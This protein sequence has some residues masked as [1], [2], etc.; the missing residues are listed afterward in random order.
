[1]A[2]KTWPNSLE[3]GPSLYLWR[4]VAVAQTAVWFFVLPVVCKPHWEWF[5]GLPL[6]SHPLAKQVLLNEMGFLYFIIACVLIVPIYAGNYPFFEQFRI[7]DQSNYG[8]PCKDFDF[9][10][11]KKEVR[12]KFWSLTKQ[13]L[14]LY[15]FNYG[16][17][18]PVLTVGKFLV[19][20]D[21][22]SFSTSDWPSNRTLFLHNIAMTLIHEFAFYWSHRLA[23]IPSLYRYHKVH[24]AYK[25]NTIMASM[26]EHPI[27]YIVTIAGPALL[28]VILV[29]PHSFTLF[30][31][32]AW[33][34]VA[35]IDDHCGYEFPF[36]PVRWFYLAG[37]TDMH[38]YHHSHSSNFN[39]FA[40]KLALYDVLFDSKTSWMNWRN[41]KLALG[42]EKPSKK[43]E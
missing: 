23:H 21:N 37:G 16:I 12:D 20:G 31:W 13:S 10:S 27:D 11:D 18:V 28:T 5:W 17:L 15:L 8:G 9:R 7:T 41:K 32:I 2:Y 33:I 4:L 42:A 19:L 25:Q 24:H 29:S 38:E 3:N 30:Q 43:A 36:S 6:L 39:C 40:S 22:M 34:I 1:M 35:N 14:G 26:H